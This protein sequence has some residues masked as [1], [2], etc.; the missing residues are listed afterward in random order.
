M[1]NPGHL[2]PYGALPIPKVTPEMLAL[3]QT[4]SVYSLSV[5]YNEGMMVPGPMA[6]YMLAPRLRHGDLSDLRPAS[7]AAEVISMS[8]HVGTH[9][10]ALCHIGEHRDEHGQPSLTGPVHLFNG[11]N[12]TISASTQVNYQGQTHMSIAEMPPIVTR[13]VLLDIARL[14]DVDVLPDS[15]VITPEDIKAAL[16]LQGSEIRPGTAVLIRTGFYQHLR[17]GNLAYRDAIA[18][19]GLDTARLLLEQGMILA[20]ADNMS[21]EAVPPQDHA[22]HRFLLVR[23]G[24]T[25][26]ENLYLDQL[27]A[28]KVYEF[29]LIV[30]PLRLTGATGSWVHPIAIA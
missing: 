4:G 28:N 15:Y 8:I 2:A 27:A 9:I 6:S 21:V 22:V 26:L 24:V 29:L 7:A 19:I 17:D 5:T 30:T 18:G 14:K 20:G 10:D 1:M 11:V 13:A 25:H 3:V 23:N 12:E 16:A